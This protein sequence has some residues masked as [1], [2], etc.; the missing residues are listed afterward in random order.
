M[1]EIQ[2]NCL[3]TGNSEERPGLE[4]G[5]LEASFIHSKRP[6]DLSRSGMVRRW[7]Q[8]RV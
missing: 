5:L 7:M 2:F 1:S 3:V 4:V 8:E 6:W